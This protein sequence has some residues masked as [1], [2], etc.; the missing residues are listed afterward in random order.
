MQVVRNRFQRCNKAT[1]IYLNLVLV[2]V[3][4][5]FSITSVFASC[6]LFFLESRIVVPASGRQRYVSNWVSD[7]CLQTL[8]M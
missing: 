3:A 5:D 1:V 8:E 7:I 4:A 2:N 6:C